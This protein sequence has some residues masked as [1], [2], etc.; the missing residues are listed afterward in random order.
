MNLNKR[1]LK[2][3]REL[4]IQQNQKALLDNDYLIYYD[5]LNINKVYA[6]IKA[7]Y[8]SI[9]RHKFVRLNI[10]IPD[11]YP[12]SPPEVTFINYNCVRPSLLLG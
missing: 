7:P 8:D 2:E 11:N 10:T 9:Y 4:Y 5:D 1:L 12:Y 6:I 3:I